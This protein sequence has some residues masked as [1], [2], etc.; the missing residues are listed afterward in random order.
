M[1]REILLGAQLTADMMRDDEA[2]YR[3]MQLSEQM[4]YTLIIGASVPILTLYPFLQK[5]FMKGVMIGA[6]KG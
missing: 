6:I 1:M 5:Y 4:K 3:A 2:A